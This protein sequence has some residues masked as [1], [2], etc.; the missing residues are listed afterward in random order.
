MKQHDVVGLDITPCST[1]DFIGDIRDENLLEQALTDVDVI[2]HC[3]ALHAPHV[4]IR[5][6]DEFESINVAA[7]EKLALLGIKKGIKHFVYTSTTALYGFAS[8]P[9]GTAGW[10]TEQVIAQPKSVYH[11]TKIKAEQQLE[12]ISNVFGLPVTVLQMSRCFPEPANQMAIYRMTR[13]IDAR[14]VAS[15]HQLAI[16]SRL[17]GFRRYIISGKTPFSA[18]QCQQLYCNAP[19]VISQCA[20]NLAQ[21]FKKRGWTFPKSLDRVYDSTLAQTELGWTP[22]Y[23]YEAVLDFLDNEIAEVL[24]PTSR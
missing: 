8:T 21:D 1:V 14:D 4:G 16:E 10:I 13:G 7:T 22:L 18:K 24:P 19:D 9:S 23:G 20:P 12:S 2:V 15:A 17:S 6:D 11:R 5:S 3:A